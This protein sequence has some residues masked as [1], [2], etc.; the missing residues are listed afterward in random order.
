MAEIPTTGAFV[1]SVERSDI[2]FVFILSSGGSFKSSKKPSHPFT[3]RIISKSYQMDNKF[4][5]P[6]A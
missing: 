6:G 5:M 2:V 1:T 3:D 4:F